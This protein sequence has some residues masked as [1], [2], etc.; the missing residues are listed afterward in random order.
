MHYSQYARENKLIEDKDLEML[1][2]VYSAII[3]RMEN[4]QETHDQEENY[5]L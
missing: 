4:N 2:N 3:D 1:K 5:Q